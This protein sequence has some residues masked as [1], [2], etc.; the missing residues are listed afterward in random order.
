MDYRWNVTENLAGEFTGTQTDLEGTHFETCWNG[1]MY[2]NDAKPHITMQASYTVGG[3]QK[4]SDMITFPVT[5]Y[6]SAYSLECPTL[7]LIK[8]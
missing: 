1:T 2:D 5:T 7:T 8:P 4:F 3:Y 6:E